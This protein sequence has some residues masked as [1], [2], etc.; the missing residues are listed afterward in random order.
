V[1]GTGPS[2]SHPKRSVRGASGPGSGGMRAPDNSTPIGQDLCAE[3]LGAV[4]RLRAGP[5]RSKWCAG[6]YQVPPSAPSR[7][8]AVVPATR[9]YLAQRRVRAD[10]GSP[11]GKV[12]PNHRSP[13]FTS[14]QGKNMDIDRRW[15]S[16]RW[17]RSSL[18]N[19]LINLQDDCPSEIQHERGG[20]WAGSP[21][22]AALNLTPRVRPPGQPDG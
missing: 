16:R 14:P 19:C 12:G 20:I 8:C 22:V 17:V 11:G 7:P 3:A 5:D 15:R 1:P 10:K 4:G 9:R 21:T 18:C 13:P 2:Q 6:I